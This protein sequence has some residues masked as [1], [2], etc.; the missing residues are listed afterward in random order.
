MKIIKYFLPLIMISCTLPNR[1]PAITETSS[2]SYHE[3][4]KQCVYKLNDIYGNDL[5]KSTEACLKIY[6]R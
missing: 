6:K 4:I 1:K 2:K 3:K 5:E